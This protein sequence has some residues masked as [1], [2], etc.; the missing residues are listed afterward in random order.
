MVLEVEEGG[1]CLSPHALNSPRAP[2]T[3]CSFPELLLRTS[4]VAQYLLFQF[5]MATKTCMSSQVSD[6]EQTKK[7]K[8]TEKEKEN[9]HS[10]CMAILVLRVCLTSWSIDPFSK[11]SVLVFSVLGRL[12]LENQC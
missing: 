6:D 12:E 11:A 2:V 5:H 1:P 10:L 9:I 7:R 8:K 4:E 3:T